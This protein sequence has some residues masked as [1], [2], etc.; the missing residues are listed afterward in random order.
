MSY[1]GFYTGDFVWKPRPHSREWRELGKYFLGD[2]SR[3]PFAETK[4]QADQKCFRL[5]LKQQRVHFAH[6]SNLR[7]VSKEGTRLGSQL[8]TCE[9][10]RVVNYWAGLGL[11]RKK[12]ICF[13]DHVHTR[14]RVGTERKRLVR[15]L[16]KT[17]KRSWTRLLLFAAI[18]QYVHQQNQSGWNLITWQF[19]EATSETSRKPPEQ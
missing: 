1:L 6:T 15:N 18:L 14:Q 8:T 17:K 7:Q 19:C 12:F 4:H 16:Q 13:L 11:Q 5:A 3:A 9:C 2:F 10:D